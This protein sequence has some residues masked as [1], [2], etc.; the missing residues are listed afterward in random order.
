MI[1]AVHNVILWPVQRVRVEECWCTGVAGANMWGQECRCTMT[2]SSRVGGQECSCGMTSCGRVRGEECWCAMT[3]CSGVRGQEHGC[4]MTPRGSRVRGRV[5]MQVWGIQAAS[6]SCGSI[7]T[8]SAA[9]LWV[10]RQCRATAREG[11]LRAGVRGGH[12]RL[13]PTTPLL[14]AC[15]LLTGQAAFPCQHG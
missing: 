1:L 4:T 12:L 7:A 11:R 6:T 13:L 2:P 3:S 10:Q 8:G 14:R 15:V 9:Q 5:C